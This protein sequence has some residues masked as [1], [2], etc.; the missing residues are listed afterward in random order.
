MKLQ[1]F[2][3]DLIRDYM[4]DSDILEIGIQY[5]Q[6][7][8]PGDSE[9]VAKETAIRMATDRCERRW[10]NDT[11]G[12]IDSEW[13][14]FSELVDDVHNKRFFYAKGMKSSEELEKERKEREERWAQERKRVQALKQ[15]CIDNGLNFEEENQKVLRKLRLRHAISTLFAFIALGTFIIAVY[16]L[17]VGPWLKTGIFFAA[18]VVSIIVGMT[19]DPKLPDNFFEKIKDGSYK[20]E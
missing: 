6:Q 8:S 18:C 5:C 16:N 20:F 12:Y 2:N 11:S 7:V 13:K 19:V 10:Y 14:A 9:L 4:E 1:T 15:Y 17:L 3:R